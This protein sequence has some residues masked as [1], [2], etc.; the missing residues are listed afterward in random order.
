MS[1]VATVLISDVV[2]FALSLVVP[3]F[4]AGVRLGEI[5]RD[6]SL[7]KESLAK[8]EGMFT[9]TLRDDVHRK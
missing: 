7:L 2:T 8:I 3:L 5:R 6:V 4:I 1:P 9:L